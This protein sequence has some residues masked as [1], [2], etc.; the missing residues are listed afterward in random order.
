MTPVSTER[1]QIS[2]TRTSAARQCDDDPATVL[3]HRIAVRQPRRRSAAR[4]AKGVTVE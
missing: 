2:I 3:A 4:L 1:P